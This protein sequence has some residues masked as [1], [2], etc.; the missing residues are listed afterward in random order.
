MKEINIARVIAEKRKEKGITQD[1]LAN[2]IGVSKAS[3]SKWETGQSYPDVTFLPLLATYFNISIDELMDYKP[4]MTKEDI[5]LLYKRLAEDFTSKPVHVVMDECRQIIKK[6]Y[7]C[8]PLLLQMGI[9]LVN[10]SSLFKE[11]QEIRGV[12]EEAKGLFIRIREESGDISLT[13]QALFL[14]ALCNLSLNDPHGVLELLGG[15][16]EPVM[17]PEPLLASAYQMTGRL[18]EAKRVLQI[19]MFQN[20]V[21]LFNLFPGYLTLCNDEP[22]IFEEV[23]RRALAIVE[24]FDLRNLHPAIV[25]GIYING[26]QGYIAQGNHD[27]ALELLQAYTTLVTG[28]IYPLKLHGDGFF[29]RIDNW[30]EDLDLGTNLPRD[31]KTI[32]QSMADVVV[33]NPIFAALADNKKFQGI[34]ARLQN[35]VPSQ[36][37]FL[38]Q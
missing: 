6:Y 12:F 9:L 21:A 23:L 3:V 29:D 34:I 4:Q 5:R 8:F 25:V 30:L 17:P 11:P 24:V 2:Y 22:K 32:R 18:D 7:S 13:K 33:H 26:A 31:E 10:H 28:D 19:G 37:N 15:E 36:N 14:E 20:I 27:Q 38:K 35:N 1:E 16:V